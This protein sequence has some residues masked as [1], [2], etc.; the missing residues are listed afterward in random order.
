[1]DNEDN[2][3]N[4]D[5]T[6][7]NIDT[8]KLTVELQDLA[9]PPIHSMSPP[10]Q[11]PQN[12]FYEERGSNEN[13][14]KTEVGQDKSSHT[15]ESADKKQSNMPQVT[16]PLGNDATANSKVSE[17]PRGQ[18]DEQ[19]N[20]GAK[21]QCNSVLSPSSE[22]R[23]AGQPQY[24][25]SLSSIPEEVLHK[26]PSGATL[27]NESRAFKKRPSIIYEENASLYQEQQKGIQE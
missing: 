23:R 19:A 26:N 11:G 13:T 9:M 27:K 7:N 14:E 15:A 5:K 10:I 22:A 18:M 12:G 24:H 6:V 16:S 21:R 4:E 3:P 25:Q 8:V 17:Y 1:M 20:D 2:R